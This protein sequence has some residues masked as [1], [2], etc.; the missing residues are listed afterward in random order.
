MLQFPQ[1]PDYHN[2]APKLTAAANTDD[3]ITEWQVFFQ[4]G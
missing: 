1:T 3:V 4:A 2:P